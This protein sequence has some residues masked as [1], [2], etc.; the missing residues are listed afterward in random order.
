MGNSVTLLNDKACSGVIDIEKPM[1]DQI[2]GLGM[3]ENEYVGRVHLWCL[4]DEKMNRAKIFSKVFYNTQL[5]GDDYRKIHIRRGTM[6]H[7]NLLKYFGCTQVDRYKLC[8][9]MSETQWFFEYE[10]LVHSLQNVI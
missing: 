4:S 1:N 5:E 3:V 7:P 2:K 8:S 6:N 10:C 9:N